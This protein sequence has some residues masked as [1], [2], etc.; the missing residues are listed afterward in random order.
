[1]G[2]K[3]AHSAV[4]QAELREDLGQVFELLASGAIT[5]QIARASPRRGTG[6]PAYAESGSITGRPEPNRARSQR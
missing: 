6:R 1:V 3:D 4:D 2:W 5:A